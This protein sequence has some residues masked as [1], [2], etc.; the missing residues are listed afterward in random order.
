MQQ[1]QKKKL[2]LKPCIINGNI[3]NQ[4]FLCFEFLYLSSSV[5]RGLP[6]VI[7]A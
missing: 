6:R 1:Q 2:Y 5:L 4:I 7:A 3:I